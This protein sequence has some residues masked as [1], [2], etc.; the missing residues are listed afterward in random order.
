MKRLLE[1]KYPEEKQDY[2]YAVLGGTLA[3]VVSE[4]LK[5]VRDARKHGDA[6]TISYEDLSSM[7]WEILKEHEVEDLF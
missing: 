5:R 1:F 7:L 2:E 6:E 3:D 4:I